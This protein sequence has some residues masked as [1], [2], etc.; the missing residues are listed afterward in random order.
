MWKIKKHIEEKSCWVWNTHLAQEPS[1]GM[2]RGRGLGEN[3]KRQADKRSFPTVSSY[4]CG[5][6]QLEKFL[7]K[8][9]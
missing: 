2:A 5:N 4:L 7:H 3:P 6:Q 8:K 9:E 1:L